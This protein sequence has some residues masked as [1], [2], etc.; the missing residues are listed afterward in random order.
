[1]L[2]D[3]RFLFLKRTSAL[4][5]HNQV[6]LLWADR[7]LLLSFWILQVIINRIVNLIQQFLISLFRFLKQVFM[8]LCRLCAPTKFER[9]RIIVFR[10]GML[11]ILIIVNRVV[12]HMDLFMNS[13]DNT[14]IA[15]FNYLIDLL[16]SVWGLSHE[17]GRGDNIPI[18]GEQNVSFF[19]AH[20]NRFQLILHKMSFFVIHAFLKW[21][22]N[23]LAQWLGVA[24]H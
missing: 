22:L 4:S 11:S 1:M 12:L 23:V 20:W 3:L 6:L 10:I 2:F 5:R 24:G 8:L 19:A 9:I 18:S 21:F 14:L 17:H 16:V 15:I 13:L 7:V